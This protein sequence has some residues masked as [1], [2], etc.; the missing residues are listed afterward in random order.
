MFRETPV[1]RKDGRDASP[2][3]QF[4]VQRHKLTSTAPPKFNM[5]NQVTTTPTRNRKQ[6]PE[7]PFQCLEHEYQNITNSPGDGV[8]TSPTH[9]MRQRKTASKSKANLDETMEEEEEEEDDEKADHPII[10]IDDE[11][12][13][14]T[15]ASMS[16]D[17]EY[18]YDHSDNDND[19]DDNK[20]KTMEDRLREQ[21]YASRER[22][23]APGIGRR[24]KTGI[25]NTQSQTKRIISGFSRLT[26]LV[27]ATL[28]GFMLFFG[29][30]GVQP[31]WDLAPFIDRILKVGDSIHMPQS[32]PM[33]IPVTPPQPEFSAPAPP[34]HP[35][36]SSQESSMLLDRISDTVDAALASFE[37][38]SMV[39]V[40]GRFEIMEES[41]E[42]RHQELS[43]RIVSVE[44]KF[45]DMDERLKIVEQIQQHPP[46]K[47]QEASQPAGANFA[48]SIVGAE[49]IPRLTSATFNP[50]ANTSWM[51]RQYRKF[52]SGGA[53]FAG[54][55]HTPETILTPNMDVGR[56]WPMNGDHGTIAV[57][58]G[59]PIEL[60][61]FGIH[62]PPKNQLT[63]PQS[64][65][66]EGDFYV[67]PVDQTDG[68][69][70]SMA[71]AESDRFPGFYKVR[72]FQYDINCCTLLQRFDL[73]AAFLD[74]RPKIHSV[75]YKLD[76][77]WGHSN[78]TCIYQ[79]AAYGRSWGVED[80]E[81]GNETI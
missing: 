3:G 37:K 6:L 55:A 52:F 29:I 33:P 57:Q 40:N 14:V 49:I 71:F 13:D 2:K 25:L 56:C 38:R 77:N 67:S 12:S 19:Y 42:R 59:E 41:N 27:L 4:Y 45:N 80:P 24:I 78:Y 69:R 79:V 76:S 39:L 75:L 35:S 23:S 66:R 36:L 32:P 65:P 26:L 30:Y 72:H 7:I 17:E 43:S 61:A 16:D 34:S 58:L 10:I 74:I 81:Q 50:M 53:S 5:V 22:T 1:R 44:Q 46:L 28:G 62:H 68:H 20:K 63:N 54:N 31:L 70:L 11:P 15:L 48:N 9:N 18:E 60:H 47:E 8:V 51:Y 21:Y 73:P 64:A